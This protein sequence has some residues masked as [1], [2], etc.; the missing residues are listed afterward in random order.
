MLQ[1]GDELGH[2]KLGQQQQLLPGL[3]RLVDELAA[4]PP[5]RDF[6]EF[7]R[8][9]IKLRQEHAAF[10]EAHLL[11]RQRHA[12]ARHGRTSYWLRPDALQMSGVDCPTR[13]RAASA[14]C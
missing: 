12:R 8:L 9:A 13:T 14:G 2:T 4:R 11:S 1:A 3:A 5:K 7:V 6:L 10:P